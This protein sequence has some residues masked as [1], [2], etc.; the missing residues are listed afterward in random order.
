MKN[1]KVAVGVMAGFMA[2]VMLL[3]LVLSVIG[4]TASAASK[5]EISALETKKANLANRRAT[6]KAQVSDLQ[7]QQ[8]A[9]IDQKKA[10]DDQCELTRQEIELIDEQIV[11]HEQIIADKEVELEAAKQA[12]Q[13]QYERYRSRVRT[14]EES[15]NLSYISVLFQATNFTDLLGRFDFIN[16]VIEYDSNLEKELIAAR[17]LVEKVKAEYEAALAEYEATK[18]ELEAK[19]AQLEAEIEEAYQMIASL[20]ADINR[21]KQEEASN[22]AAEYQLQSEIDSMIAELQK[23]EEE[24][25]KAAES[26]GQTWSG[27]A[28]AVGATGSYIWPAPASTVITSPFGTRV[29]PIFK[30]T[31]YH[32]GIDIGA[33][34]GSLALAADSGT[35]TTATYSSS[36]GNYVV[37]NHGNGN[38]TLYAHM[39]SLAVSAGQSISQGSTVGYV[40]S[41]GWSTGPHLHF[42][43]TQN[44]SR[45]DPLSFFS[46]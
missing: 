31:K 41:T 15:G 16:E 34:A 20:E 12:E 42:E 11:I 25:K 30:T 35:V 26:S 27:G 22:A 38:T 40:G 10:L 37:I 45:V 1:R 2:F 14:M 18:V 8:A 13:L 19:K 32:A 39:S 7:S 3:T 28:A 6:L 24:A 5:A 21:Y 43:V 9:V 23:Q 44:G 33:P 4:S 29:H 36:Y 17:E 46:N